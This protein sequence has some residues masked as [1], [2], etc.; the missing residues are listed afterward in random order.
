MA[1]VS[2][3]LSSLHTQYVNFCVVLCFVLREFKSTG[4][5]I[6]DA[7]LWQDELM[8]ELEEL[9]QEGLDEK[10]LEVGGPATD[11]LPSVPV[12]EP[13]APAKGKQCDLNQRLNAFFC[14]SL[15]Q[16]TSTAMFDL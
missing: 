2:E 16:T 8:A 4:N 7:W 5:K 10:L 9:E 14:F 15:Q 1:I 12:A 6:N 3:I 11:T 13:K